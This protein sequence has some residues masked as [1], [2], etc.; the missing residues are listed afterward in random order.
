MKVR[1]STTIDV[2]IYDIAKDKAIKLSVALSHGILSL[3]KE[4]LP[5]NPDEIVDKE[6]ANYRIQKLKKANE[7]MQDQILELDNAIQILE[8]KKRKRI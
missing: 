7:V 1:I 2:E 6:T 4:D 3:A 8:N 5:P